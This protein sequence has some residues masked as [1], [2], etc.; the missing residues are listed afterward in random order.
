MTEKFQ[1]FYIDHVLRQHNAHADA[2]AFLAASLDLPVGTTEKVLVH[3][4]HLH[5]SKF[6][7]ED[8]GTLRGDLQVK[9]IFDTS[10]DPE[11]R[12]WLFTFINFLNYT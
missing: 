4:H 10:T 1:S 12:D 3:S 5:C 9:E 7:L 11:L 6:A 2:L 8:S